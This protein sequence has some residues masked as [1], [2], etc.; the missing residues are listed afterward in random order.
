MADSISLPGVDWGK[1][2]ALMQQLGSRSPRPTGATESL[3]GL[4]YRYAA[5]VH[6]AVPSPR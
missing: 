6:H 1:F 3:Q 4:R 5:C 2:D